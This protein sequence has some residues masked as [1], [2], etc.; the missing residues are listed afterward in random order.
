MSGAWMQT[1]TGRPFV[2]RAP[3]VVPIHLYSEIA[4]ALAR[5]PRFNGHT[6]KPYSVAQ[7]SVL[8]AEAAEIETGD[9]ELAA[10][11]LLHDA[12]EAYVG[13]LTSPVVAA[14]IEQLA[15]GADPST[16]RLVSRARAQ[17]FH[18]SWQRIKGGIDAEITYAA[19]LTLEGHMAHRA[20]VKAIDLR[21]LRTERDDL[22]SP[23]SQPWD[24]EIEAAPRLPIR[25]G[26]I[27][28]LPELEARA[29]FVSAL[30]RLCPAI[31]AANPARP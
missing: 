18:S 28:P 30:E 23:G 27:R 10:H 22:K 26:R 6:Q 19:G 2:L 25:T 17:N 5:I 16:V 1:I 12:H 13:D 11:C 4:P 21:A 7:H 31:A 29:L 14:L 9:L 15:D 24:A 3:H 8:C 20:A